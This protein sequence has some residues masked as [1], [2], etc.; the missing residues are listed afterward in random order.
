MLLDVS[1][2][3][4]GDRVVLEGLEH[5]SEGI[6][7]R[8]VP[9][10][11]RVIAGGT[12]RE[13]LNLLS[14]PARG[15]RTVTSKGG[16]QRAVAQNIEAAG[17]YPVPRLTGN[18]RRLLSW[19]GPNSSKEGFS[20]GAYEATVFDSAEYARVIHAGTGSSAKY[21]PRPFLDDAFERFNT[22]ERARMIV[23]QKIVEEKAKS[24]LE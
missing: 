8:A 10:A 9:E 13:A 17:G 23:E 4:D 16:R 22:G 6:K 1:V 5:Y 12:A 24:G 21:G 3:I 19:I 15:L 11:L 7:S 14:G 2:R 18:L 20:T